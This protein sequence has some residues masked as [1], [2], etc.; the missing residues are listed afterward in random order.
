MRLPRTL[1]W[2][3]HKRAPLPTAVKTAKSTAAKKSTPKKKAG[4]TK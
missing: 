3:R 2:L 4:G 1:N